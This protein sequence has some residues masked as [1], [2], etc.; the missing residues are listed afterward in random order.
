MEISNSENMN[1]DAD[2]Y[3]KEMDGNLAVK[4]THK[5]EKKVVHK[6]NLDVSAMI[7]YVSELTNGGSDL[8]C[9][10]Q[11]LNLQAQ[12]EQASPLLPILDGL[13]EGLFIR[14]NISSNQVQVP[15]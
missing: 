9:N 6:L 4:K 8:V 11:V 5:K 1:G 13:F 14:F 2:Y 15:C 10:N 7:G 3:G 12:A